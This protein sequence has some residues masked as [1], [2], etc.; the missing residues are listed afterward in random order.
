MTELIVIF[1]NKIGNDEQLRIFK[2]GENWI[3]SHPPKP[4]E[5]M[6]HMHTAERMNQ[7]FS[8]AQSKIFIHRDIE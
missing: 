1:F 3:D 8:K 6:F 7:N 2:S 4:A 5:L